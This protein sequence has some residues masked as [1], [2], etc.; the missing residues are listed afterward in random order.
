[1]KQLV[2]P[3]HK[4]VYLF[5][6]LVVQLALLIA[7]NPTILVLKPHSRLKLGATLQLLLW[8][9]NT[10]DK[11]LVICAILILKLQVQSVVAIYSQTVWSGSILIMQNHTLVP[12]VSSLVSSSA[13]MDSDW[14]SL[15]FASL[16]SFPALWFPYLSS[17]VSML[18]MLVNS[19]LSTIGWLVELALA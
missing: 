18:K 14:L 17:M 6:I 8:T 9:P 2:K 15:Q 19:A 10:T 13:S 11:Y 1:M 5:Y 3:K 7:F 4:M 16:V 12:P